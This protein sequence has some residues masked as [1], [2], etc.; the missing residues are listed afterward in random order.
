MDSSDPECGPMARPCEHGDTIMDNL[1]YNIR[2]ETT[3]FSKG[4]LLRGNSRLVIAK[5]VIGHIQGD[6]I[7]EIK[8]RDTS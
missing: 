1:G 7:L 3:S 8:N 2:L 6:Q 4:I 5:S